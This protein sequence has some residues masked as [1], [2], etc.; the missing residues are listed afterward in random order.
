M[1]PAPIARS[2]AGPKGWSCRAL[3]LPSS[4]VDE[5]GSLVAAAMTNSSP[6]RISATP[7]AMWPATP[8]PL[9]RWPRRIPSKWRSSS[10]N[11][12]PAPLTMKYTPIPMMVRPRPI[13]A[14]TPKGL[15][16][17]DGAEVPGGVARIAPVA[18]REAREAQPHAAVGD[19][20]EAGGNELAEP[21]PA[22]EVPGPQ[23]RLAQLPQGEPGAGDE[24][25]PHD[26]RTPRV[27]RELFDR[28]GRLGLARGAEAPAPRQSRR[29]RCAAAP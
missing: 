22:R 16:T 14:G 29:S 12:F 26:R 23:R 28:P 6:V 10:L 1:K 4:P 5:P 2:R 3:R 24:P 8:R 11:F 17:T 20:E 15:R 19:A 21:L 13:S 27:G 9:I 25:R 18:Q 7:L